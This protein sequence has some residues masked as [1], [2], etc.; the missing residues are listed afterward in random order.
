MYQ[1][2]KKILSKQKAIVM[3][4]LF[5]ALINP[6][7]LN[8]LTIN[9][10]E[11]VNIAADSV[12]YNYKT[13]FNQYEG[14]VKVDQGNAHLTAERLI[15]RSNNQHQMH[16]A[17]AYG[18]NEKAHY[19][20]KLK[21]NEPEIHAE[22]RI[23]KFYPLSSNIVLEKDVSITRGENHFQGELILYN[24]AE[25]TITVPPTKNGRAVIVYNPDK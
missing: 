20:T 17:I 3:F 9:A 25:Q 1:I 12:V 23:I 4:Y 19:W 18:L 11:K 21:T 2:I 15:T 7:Q 16:E 6:L 22:A 8:A 24:Q 10:K 5:C 13:G 14:H